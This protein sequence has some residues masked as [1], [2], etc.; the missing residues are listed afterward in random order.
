[1]EHIGTLV[2]H[3]GRNDTHNRSSAVNLLISG[4]IEPVSMF[5]LQLLIS[6]NGKRSLH[7]HKQA[8]QCVR[9]L[10]YELST[11]GTLPTEDTLS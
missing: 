6:Q 3:D 8:K 4:G 7:K 11:Q 5:W 1:M 2:K 9:L 10:R